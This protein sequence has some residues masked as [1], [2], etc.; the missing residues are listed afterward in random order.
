MLNF[1]KLLFRPAI[2][3][4][5]AI[6]VASLAALA[7]T[8]A[9][10]APNPG[11]DPVFL[12]STANPTGLKVGVN[13]DQAGK[14]PP[15]TE[16]LAKKAALAASDLDWKAAR[17]AYTQMLAKAPDNS[18]A[19]S[20][21]GAVEF[22]LGNAE[23][24]IRHLTKATEVAPSIAQNWLTL[25]LIHYRQDQPNLA[26]SYLA[27]ALHED[28]GDPRAHNYMGVLIRDRGWIVGAETE[29]QRALVIDPGYADAHFNL[30][31]MYLGQAPPLLELARRHY[32]AAI[33]YGAKP[34]ETIERR[35][36]PSPPSPERS[37]APT[38]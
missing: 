5:P 24:A 13:P 18:L 6:L 32:Y 11:D 20:N 26:L 3:S 15:G 28:P 22:R 31:V 19:L 23:A 10:D 7:P 21:L 14:F 2:H 37:A 38:P 17:D 29:L 12:K 34:D 4:L 9:Q 1:E 33:D 35:L 36:N 27:R 16:E 8:P 30:A 25:G